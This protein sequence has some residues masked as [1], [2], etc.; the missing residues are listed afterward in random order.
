IFSV[1]ERDDRFTIGILHG[2]GRLVIA[3]QWCQRDGKREVTTMD[4]LFEQVGFQ[5]PEVCGILLESWGIPTYVVE[6]IVHHHDPGHVPH[7]EF[8]FADALHFTVAVLDELLGPMPGVA[9]ID[10]NEEHLKKVAG[11]E[12]LMFWRRKLE[13]KVGHMREE[14]ATA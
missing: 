2:L 5:H 4:K 13:E 12:K 14:M 3:M 8:E 11:I 7:E 10:L 9:P 6:A 1:G